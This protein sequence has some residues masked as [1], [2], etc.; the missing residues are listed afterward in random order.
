MALRF[1]LDPAWRGRGYAAE[2]SS[3]ALRFAHEK[4]RLQRVVAVARETNAASR[5]LL[6]AIGMVLRESFMQHDWRMF[7]YESWR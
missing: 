1:A 7:L 3:A 2:A 4:G 6:A 5:E